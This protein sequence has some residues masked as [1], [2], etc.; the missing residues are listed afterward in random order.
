[1]ANT[2]NLIAS[3]DFTGALGDPWPLSWVGSPPFTPPRLAGNG[4]GIGSLAMGAGVWRGK[5]GFYPGRSNYK[6]DLRCRWKNPGG[7]GDREVGLIVRMKDANN[8]LVARLR[9]MGAANPELRLYKRIAGVETLLGSYSGAGLGASKLYAGVVWRVRVED[10][11]DGTGNTRVTVYTDA[12]G[13][14][15]NGT[16]RIDWTGSVGPLRGLYTVGVDLGTLVYNND[17]Y[18]DDLEVYDFGDEWVPTAPQNGGTGWQVELD[19]TLYNVNGD[20]GQLEDL[21]PPVHLE[22]V[23]QGYGPNGNTAS[24]TVSGAFQGGAIRPNMVVKVWWNGSIVFRGRILKGDR[25]ASASREGS[26]WTAYDAFALAKQ[27]IISDDDATGTRTYNVEDRAADE[28][29]DD[30]QDMELGDVIKDHFDTFTDGDGGL[31]YYGAAPEDGSAAYQVN[32]LADLDAVVPGVSTSNNFAA[33][34]AQLTA[35]MPSFQV[36]VDPADLVWH[37]RDVTNLT[38]DTIN[39]TSEWVVNVKASPDPTRSYTKVRWRGVKK[40]R[41][42]ETTYEFSSTTRAD[43]GA[44]GGPAWTKDQEDNY[45][46]GKRHLGIKVIK[47]IVIAGTVPFPKPAGVPDNALVYV[48]VLAAEGLDPDDFRGAVVSV[49]GDAYQR[50]CV[51]H[52]STRIYLGSPL[53]GGGTPP[54]PGS[55]MVMSLVDPD[56]IPALSAAGVGRAFFLP[57]VQICGGS[58][59]LN[60]NLQNHGLCGTARVSYNGADGVTYS[61]E[62]QAKVHFASAAQSGGGMPCNPV[63]EMA[64]KPKPPIG[65][66]NYLP[67]AGG[68]PPKTLCQPGERNQPAQFP[69]VKIEFSASSTEDD[70]P[71]F[72]EP[73]DGY[74]GDAYSTDPTTWDG[75][76]DPYGDDWGVRQVYVYDDPNFTDEDMIPGLRKA[77]ASLLAVFGQR[78]YLFDAVMA[79]PWVPHPDALPAVVDEVARWAGL[80]KHVSLSSSKRTTTFESAAFPSYMVTWNVRART[81]TIRAGTAAGW[82]GYDAQV[83]TRELRMAAVD[84]RIAQVVR[85]LE[86]Y[87]NSIIDK[88]LKAQQPPGGPIPACEVE[89]VDET[90]RRIVTVEKKFDDDQKVVSA[91]SAAVKA[92][93]NLTIGAAQSNPGNNVAPPGHDAGYALPGAGSVLGSPGTFEIAHQG[94]PENVPN[95]DRSRYGG[96]PGVD[97]LAAFGQPSRVLLKRAGLVFRTRHDGNG[98]ING[99]EAAPINAD[100]S[101]PAGGYTSIEKPEDVYTALGVPLIDVPAHESIVGKVRRRTDDIAGEIG[102]VRGD[103]ADLMSP[104]DKDASHPDGAPA[105]I[106]SIVRSQAAAEGLRL[107]PNTW[108]DPGG[109]VFEGPVGSVA[110]AEMFWRLMVP[111]NL[112]VRVNYVGPGAG[113]NGGA[114]EWDTSDPRGYEYLRSSRIVH[115]HKQASEMEDV[116]AAFGG[117]PGESAPLDESPRHP[118]GMRGSAWDMRAGAGVVVAVGATFTLPPGT[119]GRIGIVAGFRENPWRPLGVGQT[120]DYDIW[121]TYALSPWTAPAPQ[122]GGSVSGDATGDGGGR[123]MGP[124]DAVPPGLRQPWGPDYSVAVVGTGTGSSAGTVIVGG[125]GIEIAQVD[126]GWLVRIE[127]DMGAADVVVSSELWEGEVAGIADAIVLEPGLVKPEGFGIADGVFLEVNP[128]VE[129]LEGIGIAD[130]V[131]LTVIP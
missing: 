118:W 11:V 32:E 39:M 73:D 77:A 100:G 109:P 97:D 68:S 4:E 98:N 43:F 85:T 61:Q 2:A 120:W 38:G 122:G 80:F 92:L 5:A 49:S 99:I 74:R 110:N 101:V 57:P 15:G 28:Y 127:E 83:L 21:D 3:R 72:D 131:E 53:W 112:L 128:P 41:A 108:G 65:L 105:S 90:N 95:A 82:L 67:P 60:A 75:G 10:L 113:L 33:A 1:M 121:T 79:T 87:R 62:Y 25:S 123:F 69:Q 94:I 29:R 129:T 89:V 35:L 63:V 42:D 124:G 126:S 20:T 119:V 46:S 40:E 88:N 103:V 18:V 78:V 107:V 86:D 70:A 16:Q 12:L 8:Y 117:T 37:F 36:W 71:T 114:W 6:A 84:K 9:S 93:N 44:P 22:T 104:G 27:V 51:G 17:V 116:S 50:W 111:E 55:S 47:S 26:A 59:Y 48:D 7:A 54:P 14:N 19:G 23:T 91:L 130:D 64:E 106:A 13:P 52:T 115:L 45:H 76:G 58:K 56:A 125:I 96:I 66:V 30:R 102:M 31:R 34:I 81:T 24:F